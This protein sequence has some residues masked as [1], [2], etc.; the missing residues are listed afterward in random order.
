MGFDPFLIISERLFTPFLHL[1][2]YIF[3]SITIT[4]KGKMD[5]LYLAI[6]LLFFAISV[7]LLD[8]LDRL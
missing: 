2:W 5:I 6:T 7:W 8:G 4:R 1:H 3:R